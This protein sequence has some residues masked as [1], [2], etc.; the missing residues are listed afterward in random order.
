MLKILIT[1]GAGFIGSNL[2]L[3]LI[4]KGHKV[5]VLDNLS[6]QIHSTHPLE[7]SPLY[8]SIHNKV[9]FIHGDVTNISDWERAIKDQEVIVHLAAETGTGQSMYQ[10]NKYTEVNVLGTSKMLDVLIN[11]SSHSIKKVIL[12][13][14]RA[15]YGEG[16]YLH[17]EID[18]VYPT[19]RRVEDMKKGDF[20]VKYNDNQLLTPLPTDESSKT[21]PI[22]L[23]GITKH[24]QEQMIMTLCAAIGIPAV[25]LRYQNVYGE[26]QSLLNPYTGILSI[27]SA[28]ILNGNDINIFEDGKESRDFIHISDVVDATIKAIEKTEANNHIF[29]VG[30]GINTN[31]ITVANELIRN[32]NRT[33]NAKISGLFRIGD[34]R[35]NFAD[36]T[37]IKNLLSFQPKVNF[38]EGIQ[39]FTQWVLNQ[40]IKDVKFKESIEEMKKKGLLK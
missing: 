30:T 28:Q 9:H 22:S 10:V 17:P 33:T 23:Y 4:D 37:K 2:S 7:N 24:T 35:H 13:S 29:N 31:I 1:G 18:I 19:Q 3:E 14:S 26:G 36:I 27:F 34:I 39:K 32:Y 6:P 5:T 16:K 25:S 8:R 15:L 11:N 20:E 12:A 38:K 40:S 21:H